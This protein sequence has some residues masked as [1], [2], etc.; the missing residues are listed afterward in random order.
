MSLA[1]VA[2][3][4]LA[5]AGCLDKTANNC[6]DGIV[7]PLDKVCVRGGCVLPEQIAQCNGA[8]DGQICSFMNS[9][10]VCIGGVCEPDV[11]GNG[12][13]LAPEECDDGAANSDGPDARCR[14]DCR[15][16]RCGDG[17]VDRAAGEVCDNGINLPGSGCSYGCKSNETCGN[18]FL[19]VVKIVGGTEVQNEECD[20]AN[21]RGQDGCSST[22]VVEI[23]TWRRAVGQYQSPPARTEAAM[24]Y[25]AARGRVVMFGGSYFDDTWE[26]DGHGWLRRDTATAPPGRIRGAMAYDPRRRRVVLFG[27]ENGMGLH[28]TWEWNGMQWTPITT[29]TIPPLR[30][31]HSMTYDAARGTIVV[32]G[33]ISPG[34]DTET[35]EYD[36]TDW[37]LAATTGPAANP[38]DSS[39]AFDAKRGRVVY[40]ASYSQANAPDITETWEWD[41]ASWHDMTPGSPI[42]GGGFKAPIVYDARRGRTVLQSRHYDSA[43][44]TYFGDTWTWDGST[45]QNIT[46]AG[47]PDPG[48]FGSM[49]YDVEHDRIVLFS[50][51]WEYGFPQPSS[52]TYVFDGATWSP[53]PSSTQTSLPWSLPTAYDARRGRAVGVDPNAATTWEWDGWQWQQMSPAVPP[54]SHPGASLVCG[55]RRGVVLI[56]GTDP[57]FGAATWESWAWDGTAWTQIATVDS[58]S[59]EEFGAAYDGIHD[60]IIAFGNGAAFEWDVA[61]WTATSYELTTTNGAWWRPA[62]GYD[63]R[64]GHGVVFGGF[65]DRPDFL[66]V[67]DTWDFDGAVWKRVSPAPA[68]LAR[69]GAAMAYDA[70]RGRIV[71]FGGYSSHTLQFSDLTDLWEW[72]GTSWSKLSP[73]GSAPF[74]GPAPSMFYDPLTENEVIDGTW[75]LRWES[76]QPHE[77]CTSGFDVDGDGL[78]GCADPDCWG[79]CAPLC[80]PGTSCDPAAPHCG[81][82]TCDPV[83]SCRVCP[84]DCGSCAPICGD[85]LCDAGESPASCPGDCH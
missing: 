46:P 44:D 48:R 31:G 85:F 38:L 72:D 56:G 24:T 79:Y 84:G 74:S 64:T 67:A 3:L 71:M 10:A 21:L 11:C 50:G 12:V 39:M 75:V 54:P 70:G 36:G 49:T 34:H 55:G 4:A 40:F 6:G 57:D 1:R 32:F 77:V 62:V 8:T 42:I 58:P 30:T 59:L 22:C 63:P 19:D 41:G 73:A 66:D 7:C 37:T 61:S 25:D 76:A 16:Q 78:V 18:G 65:T 53:P 45:W 35:W 27:G 51:V 5:L 14:A 43:S 52:G 47:S 2:L 28:D 20:D 82:G 81:D 33:G 83:E 69:D 68:P 80:P 23:P 13:K 17:I 60:H 26:W 29:H 15:L 9:T